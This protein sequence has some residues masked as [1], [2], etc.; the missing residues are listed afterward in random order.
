MLFRS[1]DC[2]EASV[3]EAVALLGEVSANIGRH[4]SPAGGTSYYAVMM[5]D[6]AIE[7][8][9]TNWL[10]APQKPETPGTGVPAHGSG[11][12]M[13]RRIIASLGGELNTSA[14]DG[15]WVLYARIP[16]RP[17]NIASSVGPMPWQG[18]A[19]RGGGSTP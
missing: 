1:G 5:S 10:S 14:E 15:D 18:F 13:H 4:L 8:M 2:A 6:D 11:R 19:G 7:I 3:R 9:E 17:G 12:A 16:T